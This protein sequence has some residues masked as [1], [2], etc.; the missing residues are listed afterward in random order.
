MNKMIYLCAAAALTLASCSNDETVEVAQQKG[1]SFR[2]VTGLNT[3]ASEVTTANLSEIL[4]TAFWDANNNK[5]DGFT[6]GEVLYKKDGNGDFNSAIP[7]YWPGK[8]Q[9]NEKLSFTAFSNNWTGKKLSRTRIPSAWVV[10]RLT[11][12]WTSKR[13]W[14]TLQA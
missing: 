13:I 4:V 8:D 9:E 10:S 3:R 5:Y 12:M 11:Q 6:N 14:Y 7:V 2:A 1:I